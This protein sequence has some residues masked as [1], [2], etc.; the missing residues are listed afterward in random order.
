M[1]KDKPDTT[2][3]VERIVQLEGEFGRPAGF[4]GLALF[5]ATLWI[6]MTGAMVL[7]L[8]YLQGRVGHP[9]VVRKNLGNPSIHWSGHA[10]MQ[11]SD[12]IDTAEESAMRRFAETL[13]CFA[14]VL[15]WGAAFADGMKPGLWEVERR[16]PEVANWTGHMAALPPQVRKAMEEVANE[17]HATFAGPHGAIVSRICVT[18]ELAAI[19]QVRSDPEHECKYEKV[20]RSGSRVR[21][22]AQCPGVHVEAELNFSSATSF[23]GAQEVSISAAPHPTKEVLTGKWLAA[24]CEGTRVQR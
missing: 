8:W 23:T 7:F 1:T 12:Q 21:T 3:W 22:R 9:A 18:P 13:A 15:A 5:G 20:E 10:T 16:S 24:A 4:R 2:R 6:V 11:R 14:G 17:Q 19:Y